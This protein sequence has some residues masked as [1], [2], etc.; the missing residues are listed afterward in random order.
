MPV[1]PAEAIDLVG[2]PASAAA[3]LHPLRRRILEA[4]RTPDSASGLG[5]RLGLPRQKL[6]YHL[7]LLEKASLVE[8][9]EERRRGNCVERVLRT[10][11]GHFIIDPAALGS[12]AADPDR[13]PD[14][15]SATYLLALAARTIQDLA[16]LREQAANAGKRLSTFSLST[17]IRF[18]SSE[19]RN[20]F[21]GELAAAVAT[22]VEKYHD[23]SAEGGRLFRLVAGAYPE[24]RHRTDEGEG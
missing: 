10:T 19:R 17:E 23:G 2:R 18:A 16:V 3:L 6:N 24:V 9:V 14:K 21:A 11:A 22:L 5:R 15:L 13:I 20:A 8:M 7:R 1:K 12:L 4:L